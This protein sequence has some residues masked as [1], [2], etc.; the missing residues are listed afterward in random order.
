MVILGWLVAATGLFVCYLHLSRTVPANADGASIALQA[1]QMLHG[2]LLLHGWVLADVSFYTTELPEYMVIEFVHG[3][4]PDVMHIASA[5]TYTLL[6]VL[7]ALVAKGRASGTKGLLRAAL[8]AGIMVAPPLGS[9]YVLMLEPDHV[10]SALPVLL[11]VLVLD[12]GG[13]RWFVPVL[14]F[15][16]VTWALVADQVILITAVLPLAGV[17]AVHGYRRVLRPW[18]P[19][20]PLGRPAPWFEA[21]L[22]AAA[23]AA[24]ITADRIVA[25]IRASGGYHVY[26][27]N[28]KLAHFDALP[29]N[30]LLTIQG[31]LVLFGANFAGHHVGVLAAIGLLHLVGAGLVLWAV[32]AALRRFGR[33]AISLQ[34][35]AASVSVTMLAYLLGPNAVDAN[36]SREFAAVL[37]L[38]AALAGRMLAGRLRRMRLMPALAAVLA[39]Y[40]G[41]LA[42]YSTRPAVPADNQAL[43][44]WLVSHRLH[45]GL[46]TDYWLANSTTVDSGGRVA[47]RGVQATGSGVQLSLWEIDRSW[48]SP[49]ANVANFAVLPRFGHESWRQTSDGGALVHAFG[50]PLHVYTL[51]GYT[52]L[53]W[54][55]NLLTKVG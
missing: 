14:A 3:L 29:H 16:L 20:S 25:L 53:V 30:A 7:A 5:L 38:G 42:F 54:H 26:P 18:R 39:V 36:S 33:L 22:L 31:I 24:V 46:T 41:G 11:L 34:L 13:R 49:R 12:R 19:A 23:V 47:V 4:T 6:V 44:N 43:A 8:A 15:L 28:N 45:Y 52:V 27:V 35:L 55:G 10:G 21:A 2:N 51:P 1:W 17:A 32:C 40:L 9:V 48:Y 37:P 50:R